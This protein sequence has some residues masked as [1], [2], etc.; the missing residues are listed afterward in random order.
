MTGDPTNRF[1]SQIQAGQREDDLS[2]SSTISLPKG[3]GAIRGIGEKFSVNP[4]TGTGSLTL[5][6]FSSSGRSGFSPQLSLSYDSGSGNGPFAL[7]WHL[8]ITSISR[9][10][11]KG[12]PRY[13]DAGESDI[14]ILSNAEDLMP[15]LVRNGNQWEPFSAPDATVN[16]QTYT[17]N[18]YRPRI[19]GLFARIE[20]WR[21]QSDGDTHWRAVTKDNVTTLYGQNPTCRIADPADPSRVFQW[22]MEI[23]FDDKGNVILYQYKAE[24]ATG[25]DPAAANERNRQTGFAPFTNRYLKRVHYGT[26][27]PYQREEDLSKR[28]DWLFEV[29][30]D[31]GEHDPVNPSPA[32]DPARKWS[33]RADPFSNF[34]STFDI[35]T[36]RLCRR[37]LMFH[38]FPK[39]KN[40]ES[41]YDGLVRSTNFTYDQ[42]DPQSQLIGNPI[43]TKLVSVTQ[44]GYNWDVTGKSYVSKSFPPLEFSYS[45]AKIDPTVRTIEPESLENLP[46]GADDSSYRWLDLD[47][48]GLSGILTEQAGALFYKR[49]L[50]PTNT[51]TAGGATQTLPRFAPL[52][53]LSSQPGPLDAS[54]KTQFMDLNADGHQD[55]VSLEGPLR[56]Y[57]K[58]SELS[59]WESFRAFES[60]PNLDP[61]DPNLKFVD[62]D[63]DGLADILVSEDEVMSWYASLGK[64]GFGLRQY[65]RKPID[66]EQGPALVFSDTTESI[67]VAD[68]SGDG[69]TDIVRIRNGEVCYWP[70]L[71]YGR[72]GAK[73]AMD[74]SLCFDTSELFDARRIR[75]GDIDGSGTTDILYLG[76]DNVAIYFNQSGNSLAEKQLLPGGF[77]AT[78][79]LTSVSL[80]DL[81]GQGTACLVWSS[82][83]PADNSRQM[84]YVDLMGGQKPYLL[85]GLKN[86]FGAETRVLYAP[87]TRFYVQDREAG[88]PWVTR[89]AFPVHVAE[90]VEVF[91]YIGRT[92][93]VSTYRYRH[94]YF[95]GVE[96]EFRGFGYVEQRDAESF[97]DSGSLF[98]EDTDSEA[99]ALHVPP[100]VTKTWFHTGAWPDEETV[101][102][103][104]ARDYFGAPSKTDPQFEQ[105]WEA[106]LATLL[107][108][109]VLPTDVLQA[110]GTRLPNRL[111]DE[112][113]R[114][115][116]RALKGSILRQ[117][118]YADDGTDKA[119]LPY[120]V[121]QR[122]YTIECF[123]PQT[124]NR[125]AVF[126]THAR[127]TIDH[128]YE[129]NPADPRVAHNAVLEGGCLWQCASKY[130]RCVR[131]GPEFRRASNLLRSPY[132]AHR[133]I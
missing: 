95:D 128:H 92:R 44:T 65:S 120:S 22:L 51:I 82:Q 81:L 69:L 94:G 131:Q 41:G 85:I 78:N 75:L 24:D 123:Q 21:R 4:V 97:G 3:G 11:D 42:Q 32:E 130:Q 35:R 91:D 25:I 66:E 104:M 119:D 105:K 7:G 31:Y 67:F 111:T 10:T 96:R 38:H 55:L 79:N 102:H 1:D 20:R 107:P 45:E 73:V 84:Q 23:S 109:T 76:A 88:T 72:F 30:F 132:L 49:N 60:L 113:Q 64:G 57:Y 90:R 103:H 124:T 110:D 2:P 19:E 117:E 27:T 37:V 68:M 48:E 106:F 28:T 8:S 26:Q 39:G 70:N 63:G 101:I 116:I 99:D 89:L 126:F 13:D 12:L 108:D 125:Y 115:A 36:Y 17:I 47:G 14:F 118:I 86:N 112:E 62:I 61:R 127:E 16:G 114:E 71:G 33:T 80:L 77:P 46:T 54:G 40:G 5:P 9:K 52:E 122:N 59:S 56:G 43:A 87:S 98:T 6:I 50:S 29:V 34:R 133:R 121:S 15:V 58:R 93:L 83:L 74:G 18:R 53:L 129:R 100:V